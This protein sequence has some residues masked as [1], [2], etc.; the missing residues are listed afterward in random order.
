MAIL[1]TVVT[2]LTEISEGIKQLASYSRSTQSES[3][4]GEQVSLIPLRF[5]VVFLSPSRTILEYYL[6]AGQPLPLK[7]SQTPYSVM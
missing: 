4:P 6:T 5:C 7:S 3:Q 2:L 1:P